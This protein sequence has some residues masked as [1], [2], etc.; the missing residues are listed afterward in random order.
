MEM[1]KVLLYHHRNKNVETK[2]NSQQH[3]NVLSMMFPLYQPRSG[4]RGCRP[5]G[6]LTDKQEKDL[7]LE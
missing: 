4:E 1:K 3:G 6:R 7:L 2:Q 5:M